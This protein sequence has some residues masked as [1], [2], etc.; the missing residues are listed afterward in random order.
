MA[1]ATVLW[2]TTE[3]LAKLTGATKVKLDTPKRVM[4]SDFQG[5]NFNLTISRID[6]LISFNISHPT[7]QAA[8]TTATI[9]AQLRLSA[10]LKL[11]YRRA[12]KRCAALAHQPTLM[13]IGA[14]APCG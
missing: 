14:Q 9:M 8:A 3:A 12:G 10:E 5:P 11:L 4:G 13:A 7:G 1:I 6:P 2:L